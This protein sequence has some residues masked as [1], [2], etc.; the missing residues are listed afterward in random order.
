MILTSQRNVLAISVVL[1]AASQA[2]AGEL[3]FNGGFETGGF[4]GWSVPLNIPNVS[5]FRVSS[6][7]NAHGGEYWAGLASTNLQFISQV[8]PTQAG[9][10][11]ELSFWL[12]WT[13]PLSSAEQV[14]VR[15]E[16][17][18]AL[19]VPAS[20]QPVPWT[21]YS[22]PLHADITGSFLEIGQ[23]VFPGEFQID[24]ISVVPIPAPSAAAVMVMG[25]AVALRRRRRNESERG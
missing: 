24:D 11:Y 23:S 14:L 4:S 19:I 9:Q 1:A 20:L 8:L 22:V 5:H 16:G 10:N 25:G 2:S 13:G 15:W 7:G 3:V 21:R 6:S 12:R 18:L 17:Q